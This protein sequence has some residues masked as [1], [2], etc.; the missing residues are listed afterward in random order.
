M[1]FATPWALAG[2]AAVAVPVAIHLLNR[3]RV[4]VVRWGAMRFLQES[5]LKN[6]RR[7]QM[8]DLLLLLLRCAWIAVL[9]L[10]FAR[11]V[12]HPEASA[13]AGVRLP[14][15]AVFLID[16]S[17][18][19]GQSDGL[20]T[21]M[22]LAKTAARKK[23]DELGNGSQAALFF[24][25]DRVNQAVARPTG[26]FAVVRRMIDLAEPT[27]RTS[28]LAAGVRTA[29]ETLR[30]FTAANKAI[31]V[32][33]DNQAS[34]WKQLD[35]VQPLL[36]EEPGTRVIVAPAGDR[37]EDNLAITALRTENATPVAGQL[38]GCLVEVSNFG[39]GQAT[40]IRV[41][42]SLGDGAPSDEAMIDKI[43]PGKSRTV[44]LNIRFPEA[45]CQTLTAAI[46]PDRFP[47]DNQRTLAV[48]A[49]DQVRALIV[50]GSQPKS[51]TD[52]DGFFVANAL[53]PVPPA[54]RAA[55]YLKTEMA[56]AA[57][58]EDPAL[59]RNDLVFLCN[60]GKLTDTASRNLLSYAKNG[61]AVIV[62]PGPDVNPAD[63]NGNAALRELLP[64]ALEPAAA[65]GALLAWQKAPYPHPVTALWNDEKNGTLGSVRA[66]R[67]FPLKPWSPAGWSAAKVVAA[68]ADGTPA[69][70]EKP[71][72]KG[73]AALFGSTATPRWNNLPLHPGFVPLLQRLCAHSLRRGQ[74]NPLNMP[75]GTLYQQTV[76]AE[77]AGREFSIVRPDGKGQPRPAG[78]VEPFN[79]EAV[80][81]YVSTELPGAYRIQVSGLER[82]AG[83][84][85]VQMD[86]AESNLALAPQQ[87]FAGLG[88]GAENG[89][90]QA[91]AAPAKVRREFWEALVILAAVLALCEMMLAHKF[92]L[93]K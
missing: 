41:T 33:T 82:T 86:P 53:Q 20:R 27:A 43:E 81:R 2:L 66:A 34:A 69:V 87:R 89:E 12:L 23:L 90:A 26:D 93:A 37:A 80:I 3:L 57:A 75:P 76:A 9:A 78:R 11:P 14:A 58:L 25:T 65:P 42:L 79:G 18:S 73:R 45:G 70:M 17:A 71:V 88:G 84:F 39:A 10:A 46:P 47:A 44:R 35:A 15:V 51:K 64:A 54:M 19:M 62:F 91:E 38:L 4:K 6:R 21:R 85:A 63:Y 49:I 68:Y 16:Q 29:L 48:R 72:G 36:S 67:Y 60:V 31:F 40:G 50:E 61:G 59:E 28:D 8:E 24:V 5:L 1:I 92:S 30:P 83:A 13:G 32:F 56:G 77:L 74:Q 7:L 55:Y 52:R 22:E